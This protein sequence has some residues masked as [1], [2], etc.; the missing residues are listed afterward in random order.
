MKLT[1]YAHACVRLERDG[2]V[3]VIDPGVYSE[4]SEALR[5]A[6]AVLVTHGHA[7]HVD[8]AALEAAVAEAPGLGVWAPEPLVREW[9]SLGSRASGV[10]AGQG[11]EAAGFAVRTFGDWH[12]FNNRW[13]PMIANVG[14][15]VDG[16]VFHPGDA[17]TVP[18]EP[19][20]TL[21]LPTSA[22]WSK[23]ADVLD[24]LVAVRPHTAHQLHD[25]LLSEVGVTAVETHVERVAALYGVAFDHLDTGASVQV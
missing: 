23:T 15:L 9:G 25:A 18:T 10:A 14:Y 8:L 21:L 13:T 11:F 4:A 7:D 1:K 20:D 3:L 16:R 12:A 6:D 19:V 22:P 2:R 17:F 5:G 24:Y